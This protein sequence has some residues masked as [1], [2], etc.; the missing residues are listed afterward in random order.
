MAVVDQEIGKHRG[1]AAALATGLLSLAK[2]HGEHHGIAHLIHEAELNTGISTGLVAFLTEDNRIKHPDD[3]PGFLGILAKGAGAGV[4]V[5]AT[6]AAGEGLGHRDAVR[7][8]MD[9]IFAHRPK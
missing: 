7:G 2:D 6:E 5:T 8:F 3:H 9:H 4:M 1:A